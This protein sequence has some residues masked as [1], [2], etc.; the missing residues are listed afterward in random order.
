MTLVKFVYPRDHVGFDIGAQS[1]IAALLPAMGAVPVVLEEVAQRA[2]AGI[3][4]EQPGEHEDGVSVAARRKR[5]PGAHH[6]EGA[7]FR[8]GPA[9]EEEQRLGRRCY[10]FAN[11]HPETSKQEK[12]GSSWNGYGAAKVRNPTAAK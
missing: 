8:Q 11:R 9:L 3:V 7:E 4:G 1:A 12:S 10:R 5:Q 2:S 6:A